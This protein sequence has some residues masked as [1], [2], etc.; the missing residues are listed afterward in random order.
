MTI[1]DILEVSHYLNT[2]VI[3]DHNNF[4]IL[5]FKYKD[6]EESLNKTLFNAK[7]RAL[8]G[9]FR[10]NNSILIIHTNLKQ[11]MKTWYEEIQTDD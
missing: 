8:S 2:I 9:N 11:Y 5:E 7:V 3:T 4:E 6:R 1:K 10:N